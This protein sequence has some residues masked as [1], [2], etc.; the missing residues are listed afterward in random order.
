[1]KSSVTDLIDN[2]VDDPTQPQ[3]L[4]LGGQDFTTIT[5]TVSDIVLE[6]KTPLAWYIAFLGTAGLTGI[7]F[8]MIGYLFIK[9]VG[10]W[11]A[12]MI[13]IFNLQRPDV[14]P[15]DDLGLRQALLKSYRI[16]K[17]AHSRRFIR[18]GEPFKPYR[19]VATWYLWSSLANEI[20]PGFA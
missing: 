8:L 15:I 10:V 14:W 3:E 17:N 19:T 5:E 9:G 12:Q 2:T 6:R 16:P 18:A 13:L 11:T 1:M 20:A 7:L 4:I